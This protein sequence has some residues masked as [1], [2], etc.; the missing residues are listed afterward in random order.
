MAEPISIEMLRLSI[1]MAATE[2]RLTLENIASANNAAAGYK[3]SDFSRLIEAVRHESEQTRIAELSDNWSKV[4]SGFT[5]KLSKQVALD[6]EVALSMKAAGKYQ[7]MIEVLNR[8]LAL[9]EL[10]ANGGKR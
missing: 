3:V 5:H 8:K 2:Q 10:A 1:N 9:A 4:E 6:E 7:K